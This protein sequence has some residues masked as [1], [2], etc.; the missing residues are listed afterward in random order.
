MGEPLGILIHVL[1][2]EMG[3]I[4]ADAYESGRPAGKGVQKGIDFFHIGKDVDAFRKAVFRADGKPLFFHLFAIAVVALQIRH[5][6][7]DIAEEADLGMPV[8]NQ[9]VGDIRFC[10]EA[11]N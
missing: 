7:I 6:V 1:L 11:F 4:I 9:G 2:H 3:H 10:A 5:G 8:L